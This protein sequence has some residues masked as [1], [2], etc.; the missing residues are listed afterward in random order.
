MMPSLEG[1]RNHLARVEIRPL[2]DECIRWCAETGGEVFSIADTWSDIDGSTVILF[3]SIQGGRA[4]K[5]TEYE[6]L[7]IGVL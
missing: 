6:V 7:Q 5:T 3:D 2:S 1:K 4:F